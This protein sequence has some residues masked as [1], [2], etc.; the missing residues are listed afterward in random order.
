MLAFMMF[1]PLYF[2][3]LAPGMLLA[4]WAQ[5]RVKAAFTAAQK[6]R[7]SS[8]LT[9]AQAARRILD[10]HGLPHVAVEP[11]RG[12]LGDHYDPRKRLLRLSPEVYQGR[13]LA[14]VGI[15]AHEAGHAIQHGEGYAPLEVRNAIVPLAAF[16]S[17][18]SIVI[19]IIGMMLS[20]TAARPL[21]G[22]ATW[23]L[24]EYLMVGALA[25]FSIGV[26]LQLI[27]LPVEFDASVRARRVLVSCGVIAA[28]E[29]RPVAKVLNAA[30]WTYVAATLSALLTLLYLLLRSG[31]LG[32]RRD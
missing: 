29:D 1:D 10:S 9:G 4:A 2:I 20:A 19:F 21:H 6:Y 26:L 13:D 32:G 5:W 8:G 28:A 17:N 15:A 18:T 11:G 30:A 22:V 12:F 16:G 25:L 7:A 14:A 31:L 24:G 27:N 3:L 23:G